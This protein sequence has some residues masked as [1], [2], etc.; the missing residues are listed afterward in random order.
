MDV[1]K[2]LMYTRE[3]EWAKV[4]GKRAYVGIT[5]YAQGSLGDIVFIELPEKGKEI[6][7]GDVLAVVESV[8]AAS[9]IY[10]PLSGSVSE[11]NDELL[12]EPEL[13]NQKPYEE[14]IAVIE[15]PD[16][17]PDGNFM[18]AREYE[19]FCKGGE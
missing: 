18:D 4:E 19:N 5:D 13:L 7:S 10:S 9:D 6:N 14:W 17:K 16:E 11:V 1:L 12:K 8:K 2:G 15:I 3:H